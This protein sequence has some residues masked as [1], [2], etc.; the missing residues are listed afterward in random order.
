MEIKY[1][2][3]KYKIIKNNKKE[4]IKIQVKE[5]IFQ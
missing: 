1:I 3:H 5:T 4:Q 2:L